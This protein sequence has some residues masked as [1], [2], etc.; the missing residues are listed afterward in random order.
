MNTEWSGERLLSIP[1][2]PG[3]TEADQDL[4]VGAIKQVIAKGKAGRK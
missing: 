3:L 4:V 2:W 1:L